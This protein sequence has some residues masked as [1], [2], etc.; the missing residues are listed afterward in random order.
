MRVV[1]RR[2]DNDLQATVA[3][4]VVEDDQLTLREALGQHLAENGFAA[5]RRAQ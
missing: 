5:G 4:L 2:R 1:A 3:S